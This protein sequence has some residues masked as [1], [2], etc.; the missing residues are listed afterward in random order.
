MAGPP[1]IA[2]GAAAVHRAINPRARAI[3]ND[4][5]RKLKASIINSPLFLRVNYPLN[6][7]KI[8]PKSNKIQLFF[9]K[10]NSFTYLSWLASPTFYIQRKWLIIC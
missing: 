6:T 10:Y 8:Q 9:Q 7:L 1:S 5:F 4:I 2:L 3:T